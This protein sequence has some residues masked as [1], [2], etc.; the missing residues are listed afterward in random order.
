MNKNLTCTLRYATT[1]DKKI[2][3]VAKMVRWKS[4]QQAQNMLKYTPK[5]WA[6]ILLKVINSA[7]ANAKN[8]GWYDPSGLYISTIDVWRG[9]KIK[10]I[11][12][13]S[14]SR[15]HPYIKHRSFVRVVLDTK[16]S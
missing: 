10:R 13:A 4:V 16:Q 2:N 3:L 8:N 7:V 15:V 14:R 12:F 11:K 6:G 1:S 5:K 9:M